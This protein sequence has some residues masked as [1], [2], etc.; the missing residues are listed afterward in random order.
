MTFLCPN[1]PYF[2]WTVYKVE[3][4]RRVNYKQCLCKV[5]ARHFMVKELK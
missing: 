2:L 4:Q 1:I 5:Q 3:P